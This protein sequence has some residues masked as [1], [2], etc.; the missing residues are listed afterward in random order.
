M[1]DIK[2][3]RLWEVILQTDMGYMTWRGMYGNGY[4]TGMEQV[5]TGRDP[6]EIPK[7]HLK[8]KTFSMFVA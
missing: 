3:L 1:T 7:A 6:I 8:G 2:Q 4:R 5:I